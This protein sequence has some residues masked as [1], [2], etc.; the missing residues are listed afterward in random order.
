MKLFPESVKRD[1]KEM[2]TRAY[3][4]L[5]NNLDV[6]KGGFYQAPSTDILRNTQIDY[7]QARALYYNT[8]PR[9]SNGAIFARPIVD[10]IADHIGLPI[11]T[12]QDESTDQLVSHWIN[13]RWQQQL[14]EMYR[15][16]LRDTKAWVRLRQPFPGPLLAAD[17]GEDVTLEILDAE[18]VTPYYNPIT[19]QLSRVEIAL[20][21]YIE[22]AP[23]T[24]GFVAATGARVYGR[25]HN[26]IEIITPEEYMYYDKT[27]G[28]VME[29]FTTNNSW[30]FVPMIEVFNDFD[31]T[32]NGGSSE[33]ENPYPF[34]QAFHDLLIQTRSAH[35]YH[36]DPKVKFKLDDVMNFL[37]NNFADSFDAEGKFSGNVSWKGR[38]VYFM[39]SDEDIGFIQATLNTND[40]VALMEFVIDCICMSA[41]ITEAV[42]FRAKSATA[43][44]TDE[45]FRFK[46]KI[47]RKRH[48]YSEAIQQIVKMALVISTGQVQKVPSVSWLPMQTADLV[49][50]GTAMNQIITAAEVANRAGAIS[51]STYRGKI[52]MFFPHMKD[53]AAEA[54]QVK[55][56][57]AAEHTQQ[58][59]FEKDLLALNP[60]SAAGGN[61]NGGQNGAVRGRVKLPMDMVP[62]SPG[63]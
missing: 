16:S 46:K 59:A 49:S 42:L 21:V 13:D 31:S 33:L 9:L 18:N 10:G 17:E 51:L 37:R 40:S 30:G 6:I 29:E 45:L 11:V 58:I 55:N 20:S 35:G 3:A 8:N 38:D 61:G 4:G 53:D 5:R 39:E 41:E 19:K 63:N 25:E 50:E 28:R 22:E 14:W 2:K 60:G 24:P 32:L 54:A 27:T 23:F 7:T 52:R 57:Q 26:I 62:P 1:M 34:F 48:N 44:E 36:S 47:E 15:N 56:E 12:L 43:G